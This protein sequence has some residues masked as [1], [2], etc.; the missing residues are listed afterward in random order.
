MDRGS[1]P[2][3]CRGPSERRR[4]PAN[5]ALHKGNDEGHTTILAPCRYPNF[6]GA[7]PRD[8]GL[9]WVQG[10]VGGP[11][12]YR[13]VLGVSDARAVLAGSLAGTWSRLAGFLFERSAM[14]VTMQVSK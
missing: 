8:G 12:V 14:G 9:G 10:V 3:T 7:R 4:A 1:C 2:F 6:R 5:L 13:V 11:W